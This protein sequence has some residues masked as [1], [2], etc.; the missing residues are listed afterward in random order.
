MKFVVAITGA[1]GSVYGIRVLEMLKELKIETHTIISKA[2]QLTLTYETGKK[3]EAV[4]KLASFF[5]EED[6]LDAPMAS[7]SFKH[8]GMM[9]V[10]CSTKTL[11][12]I[13]TGYESNLIAR[14]AMVTLKERR[15]L[16]LLL[17]ETPLTIIHIKNMLEAATAGAIIMPASPSF[18]TM[19]SS[20]DEMVSQVAGRVL[21]V[22]GVQHELIKRWKGAKGVSD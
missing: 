22:M 4:K 14:A 20:V 21:D 16:L 12:A 11:S 6:E 10:P 9:I 13:A 1:S 15:K 7:G 5:Y 2:A 19:P 18:Y 3:M 17:R 8:D